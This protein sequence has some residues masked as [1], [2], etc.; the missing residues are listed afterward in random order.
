[1]TIYGYLRVSTGKQELDT[2]K[3][4]IL[5]FANE[6][7]L[8]QITWIQET[9]S[10]RV[11]WRKRLLGKEFCHMKS[12]DTIIMSEFSRIG[13]NFLQSLEFICECKRKD[14]VVYSVAGDIPTADDS[15][16]NLLLSLNAWKSQ[17]ERENISFRTKIALK[18]KKDQGVVLGRK[19][20]MI[21]EK[22]E[23]NKVIIKKMIDDGVKYKAIASKMGCSVQT[24][25]KYCI[26]YDL[27]N[28]KANI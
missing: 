13:R 20:V 3:S 4:A 26:K 2:N 14:I 10:G 1:M 27:K 11:D 19:K 6:K 16:S 9:I 12:G 15:Q 8:N 25:N 28:K 23:D 5:L 24:L 17:V 7:N 22:N 21:L 18:N